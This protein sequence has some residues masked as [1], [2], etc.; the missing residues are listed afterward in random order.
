MRILFGILLQNEREVML[1][2]VLALI[3][4]HRRC[5]A[6]DREA[7]AQLDAKLKEER[8]KASEVVNKQNAVAP[9]LRNECHS[10]GSTP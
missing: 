3:H 4:A 6:L 2:T 10:L 1:G 5:Q 9:S 8:K 7:L